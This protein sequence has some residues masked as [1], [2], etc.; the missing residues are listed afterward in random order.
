MSAHVDGGTSNHF[1]RVQ[2]WE[3]RTSIGESENSHTLSFIVWAEIV[4]II[5]HSCQLMQSSGIG[6]YFSNMRC[7]WDGFY[8]D[9][10]LQMV[11]VVKLGTRLL[12]KLF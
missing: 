4:A 12:E 6:D 10:Y 8:A 7:A 11:F 5:L 3:A 9:H 2:A 1:K